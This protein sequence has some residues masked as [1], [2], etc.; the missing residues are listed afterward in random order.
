MIDRPDLSMLTDKL[1]VTNCNSQ[2]SHLRDAS[3]G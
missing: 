2:K 1:G 3:V